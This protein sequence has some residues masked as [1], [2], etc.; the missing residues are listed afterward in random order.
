MTDK[1]LEQKCSSDTCQ[2][3][4]SKTGMC[5]K[6]VFTGFIIKS[7]NNNN[8]R[9]GLCEKHSADEGVKRVPK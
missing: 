6:P 1:T 5:G 9:V 3:Y 4:L 7:W 8:V 2:R